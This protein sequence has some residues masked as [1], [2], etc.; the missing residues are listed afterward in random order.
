MSVHM[1][2]NI[3][4]MN[5]AHDP[6]RHCVV[7]YFQKNMPWVIDH[8]LVIIKLDDYSNHSPI[9]ADW[10]S[11]GLEVVSKP[12]L[13]TYRITNASHVKIQYKQHYRSCGRRLKSVFSFDEQ[14]QEEAVGVLMHDCMI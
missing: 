6:A 12:D 4:H 3:I 10:R 8:L 13:T 7:S 1:A 2:G 14:D 9:L 11:I 5:S